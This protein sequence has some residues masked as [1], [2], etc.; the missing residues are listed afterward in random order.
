MLDILNEKEIAILKYLEDKIE[1][2]KIYF[3]AR[4]IAK[5]IGSS[6][7]IVGTILYK[8]S[9]KRTKLKIVQ[10]AVSNSRTTWKVEKERT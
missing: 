2:G 5:D 10:Y 1:V 8:I 4:N 3:N 6:S 7:K 9:Q